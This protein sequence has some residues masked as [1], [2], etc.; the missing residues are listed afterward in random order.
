MR[1]GRCGTRQT[2]VQRGTE[3]AGREN[4]REH[5]AQC[6]KADKARTFLS[7]SCAGAQRLTIGA[8]TAAKH[9]S[10]AVA[11]CAN[12]PPADAASSADNERARESTAESAAAA[13]ASSSVSAEPA[14]PV[15]ASSAWIHPCAWYWCGRTDGDADAAEA[16][17][18]EGV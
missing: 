16:A 14:P 10:C 3:Q 5:R 7:L 12:T 1:R 4:E 13:A 6:A 18:E 11:N 8:V 9:C 17:A 15:A 2:L